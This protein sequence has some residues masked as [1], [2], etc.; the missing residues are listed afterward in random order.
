MFY[1][2]IMHVISPLNL[3]EQQIVHFICLE[4]D[5]SCV[6]TTRKLNALLLRMCE[7]LNN[8]AK[9]CE[10]ADELNF[11]DIT[12]PQFDLEFKLRTKE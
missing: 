4:I 12:F 2:Q 10:E 3:I 9:T 11:Y 8:N 5:N 6:T 1:F 7:T